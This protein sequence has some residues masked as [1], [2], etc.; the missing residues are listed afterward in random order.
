MSST[1]QQSQK[2][3]NS[4]N[5]F[6]GT[7]KPVFIPSVILIVLGITLGT[8]YSVEVG[9][10]AADAFLAIRE[11]IGGT[12]G[13][14]YV[15]IASTLVIFLFWVGFSK[16]G[17][18]RL[19]RDDEKPEF[20]LFSWI[21]MLFSAGVGIGVIYYAVS[22]PVSHMMDPPAV[23]GAEPG[24]AEAGR[25]AV[26]QTVWHW[27]LHAWAIYATVGL[28]MAYMTFRRGR[29]LAVRWLL[30]P[31]FG[32]KL[33][34]SWV[35]HIIDVVAVVSAVFG[36]AVSLGTG[37]LQG[38]AGLVH[39]GWVT[40]SEGLLLLVVGVITVLSTL[41]VVSGLKRGIRWLS[42]INMG[43]TAC[44]ALF[45]LLVGPTF[46]LLQSMV[47]NAGEYFKV[48]PELAF[49]TGAGATDDWSLGWTIYY[50]A[51]WLSFAPFVG[52]FIARI[53]R[54]R[55]I[56][57]FVF[58]A[59]LIPSLVGVV[60][61]SIFGSSGIWYQ[62]NR[63]S[64]A[65]S[66]GEVDIDTSLFILFENLPVSDTMVTILSVVTMVAITLYLVTSIDSG[67]LV[68]DV[69]AHGG[70]TH[71]SR[72][73]RTVWAVLTGVAGGFLMLIGGETALTVLQV[74]AIA[75]AA[76]ISIVLFLVII[77]MVRVLRYE[78]LHVP[79]YMRFHGAAPAN[80]AATNGNGHDATVEA[81]TAPHKAL[82]RFRDGGVSS[83]LAGLDDPRGEAA[84]AAPEEE[85]VVA[86]Q[87][88]PP[89]AAA[90]DPETGVLNVGEVAKD[91][92]AGE[93][94]DTPEFEQSATGAAY[95]AQEGQHEDAAPSRL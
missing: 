52:M 30:E 16:A 51:W 17:S 33:I 79:R 9:D 12:F 10:A 24:S 18:I 38:Q 19:G 48:V 77:A 92:I 87:D 42:N 8:W 39:L 4:R 94:F 91:P 81:V 82:R 86:V 26:A 22:E 35:G 25:E 62:M 13:W 63:S 34:E 64:M 89:H 66:D 70:A 31:I 67:A 72:A 23:A 28:G 7:S 40:S 37:V 15:L 90:M 74:T 60:W 3:P 85:V 71:T 59:L 58:G 11:G 44:M 84:G 14:W 68:V 69:M 1:A 49:V 50:W 75:V 65:G 47:Q 46:F 36:I 76:P 88:V 21:A 55:T 83:T 56:R 41:S 32:R 6:S 5:I 61:F 20:S 53:S 27:G 29:P 73:T 45:V 57:Q 78:S 54:G 43:L 95:R 80:A 2:S 93:I